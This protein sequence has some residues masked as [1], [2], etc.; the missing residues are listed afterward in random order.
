MRYDSILLFI[1]FIFR[2]IFVNMKQ[3]IDQIKQLLKSQYIFYKPNTGVNDDDIYFCSCGE[4]IKS[5]PNDS[6]YGI[7]FDDL[8]NFDF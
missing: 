3:H 4:I 8:N 6:M 2:I 5:N 1:F 7:S